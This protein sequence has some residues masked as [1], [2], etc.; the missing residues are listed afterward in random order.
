MSHAGSSHALERLLLAYGLTQFAEVG[1]CL[2]FKSRSFVELGQ[3]I[4]DFIAVVFLKGVVRE[5]LVDGRA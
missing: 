5:S 4:G 3:F 2:V 1:I